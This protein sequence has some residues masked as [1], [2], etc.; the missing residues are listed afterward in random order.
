MLILGAF[1]PENLPRDPIYDFIEALRISKEIGSAPDE[2][3][4]YWSSGLLY[5]VRGHFGR[6]FENIQ[7]G[8]HIA[9]EIGHLEFVVANRFA[10]GILY[11]ELLDPEQ[12]RRQLEDALNLAQDLHSATMI[13]LV[14]GALAG[15]YI[16]L[17]KP[18]LAQACLKTV[19]T[20]QTSMDTLGKRYCWVRQAELALLQDDPALA[21]DI[22]DRL[23]TSAAGMSPGRVIPYLWKLKSKALELDGRTEEACSLLQTAIENAAATGER[24][25]L[26]RL[27]AS[28]GLLYRTMGNIESAEKE[29]S[30]ARVLIDELADTVLDESL[31]D[32][33]RQGA[34]GI[35]STSP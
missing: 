34:Y 30:A 33:F 26:W 24:Y 27:H 8:L 19:I 28:L 23:I 29:I 35:L 21:L 31:M 1:V 20:S 11:I 13:H 12:A 25:L 22:T 17:D 14:S 15:A 5:T 6:A 2:T 9:S 4:A 32:S 7:S 10:L 3:W 18:K 16:M